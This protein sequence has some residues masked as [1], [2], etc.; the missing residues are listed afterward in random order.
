MQA[1]LRCAARS[2]LLCSIGVFVMSLQLCCVVALAVDYTLSH[3]WMHDWRLTYWYRRSGST[4]AVTPHQV[5]RV[6]WACFR[7][8]LFVSCLAPPGDQER[9]TCTIMTIAGFLSKVGQDKARLAA[10]SSRVPVPRHNGSVLGLARGA[11]FRML[12]FTREKE[13]HQEDDKCVTY[14]ANVVCVANVRCCNRTCVTSLV[15]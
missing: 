13:T 1:G 15:A 8:F 6:C 9:Q 4:P 7:P 10:P 3:G 14:D 2:W 5:L 12:R 11:R